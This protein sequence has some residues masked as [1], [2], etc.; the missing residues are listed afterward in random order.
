V[1][2]DDAGLLGVRGELERIAGISRPNSGVEREDG[3]DASKAWQL[4]ELEIVL[5][6]SVLQRLLLNLNVLLD[7][8]D[9][10]DRIDELCDVLDVSGDED[11]AVGV[12]NTKSLG[13]RGNLSSS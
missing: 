13:G 5:V 8:V 12:Q 4:D 10:L 6:L 9:G 2:V 1:D 11:S 7:L 3:V